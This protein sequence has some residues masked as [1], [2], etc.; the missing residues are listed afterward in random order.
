MLRCPASPDR[1][2]VA[3]IIRGVRAP[4]A[5]PLRRLAEDL[6]GGLSSGSSRTCAFGRRTIGDIRKGVESTSYSSGNGKR[7]AG[8]GDAVR[9]RSRGILRRVSASRG[10]RPYA[11]VAFGQRGMRE[12]GKRDEPHGRNR[13]AT[14]PCPARGGNRRGGERPRGRNGSR[15]VAPSARW[16]EPGA[17]R[18]HRIVSGSGRAHGIRRRGETNPKRGRSTALRCCEVLRRNASALNATRRSGGRH[19]TAS[20]EGPSHPELLGGPD[21]RRS[22]A[23]EDRRKGQQPA[24]GWNGTA[25]DSHQT[26]L[27]P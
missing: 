15:R 1:S 19:P 20:A 9:L 23:M 8:R 2:F 24:T 22:K 4:D 3:G 11:T 17:L 13:D 16:N 6:F 14:G 18:R 12:A 5:R 7:A 26:L 25:H 10:R 21:R 27:L